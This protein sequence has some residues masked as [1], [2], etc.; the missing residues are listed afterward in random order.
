MNNHQQRL[1]VLESVIV[2]FFL[3]VFLRM[4]IPASEDY[5]TRRH[6]TEAILLCD[7]AKHAV[8]NAL[9]ER[10]RLPENQVEAGYASP[11]PTWNVQSIDI[12]D[13]GS[14]DI[15]MKTTPAAGGGTILFSPVIEPGKPIT[16]DC[17]GGTLDDRYRPANCF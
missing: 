10:K 17:S 16:W 8:V 7:T 5:L 11:H 2:I 14:G 12:A 15:I 6:V 4:A 9:I 1:T 3:S 13:D